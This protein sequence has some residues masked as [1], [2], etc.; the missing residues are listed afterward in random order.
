MAQVHKRFVNAEFEIVTGITFSGTTAEA[1]THYLGLIPEA[2][3]VIPTNKDYVVAAGGGT[4]TTTQFY[5]TAEHAS[6]T[7]S[8]LLIKGANTATLK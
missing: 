5:L 3:I 4:D 6:A 7:C 1:K 2:V 8:V